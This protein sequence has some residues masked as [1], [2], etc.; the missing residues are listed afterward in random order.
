MIAFGFYAVLGIML[1]LLAIGVLEDLMTFGA[2]LPAGWSADTCEATNC[3]EQAEYKVGRAPLDSLMRR[4]V[5]EKHL[6][7]TVRLEGG[8]DHVVVFSLADRHILSHQTVQQIIDSDPAEKWLT[9]F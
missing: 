5:C 9:D 8:I 1:G 3:F 4:C 2:S 7:M 6:P